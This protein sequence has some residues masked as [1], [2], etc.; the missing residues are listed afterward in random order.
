ME[1]P[2]AAHNPK[3]D[4]LRGADVDGGGQSTS[5]TAHDCTVQ[6][7]GSRYVSCLVLAHLDKF[8]HGR[9][10]SFPFCALPSAQDPGRRA[11][12]S[13]PRFSKKQAC[14]GRVTAHGAQT[15]GGEQEPKKDR[16]AVL[17]VHRTCS[18]VRATQ[19][20]YL[21]LSSSRTKSGGTV[22]P[23]SGGGGLADG[24]TGY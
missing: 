8:S 11:P 9:L 24:M 5:Y 20:T 16:P 4:A 2:T 10:V 22:T 3:P 23:A 1:W 12:R 17:Y 15:W 14:P 18:Q 13:A 21:A 6:C 7:I 19:C